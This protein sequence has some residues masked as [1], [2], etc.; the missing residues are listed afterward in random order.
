MFV[1]IADFSKFKGLSS[2]IPSEQALL[3]NITDPKKNRQK[4]GFS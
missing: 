4:S 2:G 1:Q 3:K